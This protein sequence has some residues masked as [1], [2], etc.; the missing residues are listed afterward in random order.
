M[1]NVDVRRSYDVDIE[2]V[3]MSSCGGGRPDCD[4]NDSRIVRV[5]EWEA[6]VVEEDEA[7]LQTS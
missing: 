6:N 5:V 7:S 3:S 1:R 4:A 2:C